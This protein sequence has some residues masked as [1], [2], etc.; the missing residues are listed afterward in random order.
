MSR[1]PA[2]AFVLALGLAVVPSA[3]IRT[4]TADAPGVV[5]AFQSVLLEVWRSADGESVDTRYRR[6]E[7]AV[8]AAFDLE[9][10]IEVATGAHWAR[11][12][13]VER[14]ALVEAF[15]HYSVATYASRF[16]DY[17]GGRFEIVGTREGPG[18]RTIVETRLVL[19]GEESVA[20]DYVMEEADGRWRAVDVIARGVS[21]LAQR[22]SEYRAT[23]R[24]GGPP[25]LAAG[26]TSLADNLMTE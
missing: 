25:A 11:A 21:E 5:A 23:L 2:L 4:E 15:S 10:M 18:G 6:L 12:S 20:L 17:G 22:R 14:S 19:P 16:K 13:D 3:S 26:L 7:P 24:Q 1:S 9:R 8:E